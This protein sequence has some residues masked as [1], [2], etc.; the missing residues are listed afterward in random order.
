M[1]TETMLIFVDVSKT[2]GFVFV[3]VAERI[4]YRLGVL[5]WRGA[6]SRASRSGLHG[7]R[8]VARL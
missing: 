4:V 7:A 3:T 1:L 5:D 6:W 2:L 8:S